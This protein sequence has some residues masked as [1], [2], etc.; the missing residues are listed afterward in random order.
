MYIDKSI[1]LP[2]VVVQKFTAVQCDGTHTTGRRK[3]AK[4]DRDFCI[5][6]NNNDSATTFG[7]T[8]IDI[9]T[10]M[11]VVVQHNRTNPVDTVV[12]VR[13][14]IYGLQETYLST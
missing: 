2:V 8:F 9:A 7:S 1:V 11:I 13:A 6:G 3:K 4:M 5:R 12:N 10:H 14:R